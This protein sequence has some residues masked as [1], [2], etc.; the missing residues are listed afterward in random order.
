VRV[1]EKNL[2]Y[3]PVVVYGEVERLADFDVVQECRVAVYEAPET[4]RMA[5]IATR[6][7]CSEPSTRPA[8]AGET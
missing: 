3:E 8:S 1:A 2:A 4:M 7:A 6:W 5:S